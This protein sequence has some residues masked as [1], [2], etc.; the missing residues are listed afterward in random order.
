ML[1]VSSQ[2]ENVAFQSFAEP[3]LAQ[4]AL[5]ERAAVSALG[6]ALSLNGLVGLTEKVAAAEL[7][8]A[9]ANP[10]TAGSLGSG[11][12]ALASLVATQ[13]ATAFGGLLGGLAE[14]AANVI[15]GAVTQG[16]ATGILESSRDNRQGLT[17][18]VDQLFGGANDANID[19]VEGAIARTDFSQLSA[20]Q[21]A[22]FLMLA[23]FAAADGRISRAE[24]NALA[25]YLDLAS[26]ATGRQWTV[27]QIGD[28]A[29]I[30][31]GNYTLDLNK[32]DSS[33]V[34]TNKATGQTTR[35]WG[36]PHFEVDGQQVGT[37]K[38]P[39]TL[40]LDDGTKITI[41]SKAS[42]DGSAV[43]YTNQLVI[44]RGDRA[45]DVSGLD[46]QTGDHLA[47]LQ[48]P[49]GGRLVDL[50]APDGAEVYEN[51]EGHGATGWFELQGFSLQ[52]I[53][54]DFLAAV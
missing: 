53:N 12:S 47:I 35:I 5:G 50:L 37:F 3:A 40:N 38:G 24:A 36:D 19:R 14:R 51:T 52:S 31:L 33:F 45:L 9:F 48:S 6:D 13:L 32:S 10:A 39:L 41:Y 43:S 27:A 4:L 22:T 49:I 34:L 2:F 44:T 23:G 30:D 11:Q 42:A 8:G 54:S 7:L 46:Q 15:G 18:F 1:S 16:A 25:N 17:G 29:H 26:G 28:R 21:R 20:T